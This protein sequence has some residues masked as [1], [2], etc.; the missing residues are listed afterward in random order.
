M[1]MSDFVQGVQKDLGHRKQ[2]LSGIWLMVQEADPNPHR[3]SCLSR[4]AIVLAYAHWEGCVKSASKRYVNYINS[5]QLPVLELK[6]SLQAAHLTSQ[7]RRGGDSARIRFLGELLGEID[8]VRA[9]V[10]AINPNKCIDMEDNLSSIV[11]KDLVIGLG[12]EYLDV[13]STRQVFI[14]RQVVYARNQVAHGELVSF[15]SIDVELRIK[16]VLTLLDTYSN[17]L[18]EAVHDNHFLA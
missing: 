4:S 11:F 12:L 6:R 7:F 13:Y 2:E 15:D 16:G 18:I 17:Q 14:D 9:A 8:R 5:R 3:L 1:D 10:C